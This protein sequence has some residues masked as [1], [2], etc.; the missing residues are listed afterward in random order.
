MRRHS[1]QLEIS[2]KQKSLQLTWHASQGQQNVV[3]SLKVII[4][5]TIV[6]AIIVGV[7]ARLARNNVAQEQP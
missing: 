6:T 1:V 2:G 3:F 7:G 4:H 5:F